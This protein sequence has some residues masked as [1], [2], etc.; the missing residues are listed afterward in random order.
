MLVDLVIM[1]A[2]SFCLTYAQET[3]ISKERKPTQCVS[4]GERVVRRD[5]ILLQSST[6]IDF[7][8]GIIAS[9]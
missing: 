1:L 2:S 4:G 3:R 7:D 5:S 8:D 9:D 6:L